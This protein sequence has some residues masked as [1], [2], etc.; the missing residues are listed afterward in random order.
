VFRLDEKSGIP[1]EPALKFKSVAP[2]CLK[3]FGSN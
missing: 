2:V 3:F 1:E